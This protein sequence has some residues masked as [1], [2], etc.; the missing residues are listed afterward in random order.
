[1]LFPPPLY[2]DRAYVPMFVM[3]LVGKFATATKEEAC[4]EKA[5]EASVAGTN[6]VPGLSLQM[7]I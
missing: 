2:V 7:H 4:T 5:D 1:M 3:C 6:R